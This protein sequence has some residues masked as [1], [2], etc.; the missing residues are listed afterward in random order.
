MAGIFFTEYDLVPVYLLMNE[1]GKITEEEIKRFDELLKEYEIFDKKEIIISTANKI[2]SKPYSIEEKIQK[3]IELNP[4]N[5][6]KEIMSNII[7]PN[8]NN[9]DTFSTRT[10]LWLL[11]N[12]AFS[13]GEYSEKEKQFI[14]GYVNC[15]GIS[16][17]TVFQIEDIVRAMVAADKQKDWIKLKLSDEK[18]ETELNNKLSDMCT[19]LDN[20]QKVLV[21]NLRYV[22]EEK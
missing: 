22:I 17:E 12:M 20:T 1:D 6:S 21:S 8:R 4:L 7:N 19:E 9:R 3:S 13:D 10:V 5:Q 14:N 11:Y 2:L 18:A 16:Q 15:M